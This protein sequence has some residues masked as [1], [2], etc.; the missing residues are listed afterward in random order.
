ML[1]QVFFALLEQKGLKAIS[2][3]DDGRHEAFHRCAQHLAEHDRT[4]CFPAF[5]RSPFT[6]RYQ[7]LDDALL[8]EDR[9][10]IQAETDG[11]TIIRFVLQPAPNRLQR[12]RGYLPD[13]AYRLV[14]ECAQLFLDALPNN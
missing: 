9:F 7:V 13:S 1:F 5:I 2:V 10:G 12:Y 11:G 14:E 3:V 4:D 6:R 8:R